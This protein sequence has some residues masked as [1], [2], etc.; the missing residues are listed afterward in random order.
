[1]KPFSMN[2][3]EGPAPKVFAYRPGSDGTED[4]FDIVYRPT[5]L[6]VAATTYWKPDDADARRTAQQFVR[7]L[8]AFYRNGGFVYP[9]EWL[10]AGELI[11]GSSRRIYV[12]AKGIPYRDSEVIAIESEL[13]RRPHD[14]D[15]RND[16]RAHRAAVA[17]KS[18][19]QATGSKIETGLVDLLTD[20]KHW[21]DRFGGD[22]EAAL[23][24]A[25]DRYSAGT[26]RGGLDARPKQPVDT[27]ATTQP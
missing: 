2:E 5:G 17:L 24:Q 7:A 22:F 27:P 14:P 10:R 20:L 26:D 12:D 16:H 8:N 4:T 19:R 3:L 1:M 23:S 15:L 11:D 25:R 13:A 21:A 9:E 6:T 18:Y